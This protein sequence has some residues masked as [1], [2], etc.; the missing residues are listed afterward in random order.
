[1]TPPGFRCL[2]QMWKSIQHKAF[3]TPLVRKPPPRR[4]KNITSVQEPTRNRKREVPLFCIEEKPRRTS[5]S[6]LNTTRNRNP[7]HPKCLLRLLISRFFLRIHQIIGAGAA[8]E[9]LMQSEPGTSW[10]CE[11]LVIF[12]FGIFWPCSKSAFWVF[13]FHFF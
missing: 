5:S 1:M 11:L 10:F 12:I 4:S 13:F 6:I 7:N 9:Q 3:R 2:I 8:G